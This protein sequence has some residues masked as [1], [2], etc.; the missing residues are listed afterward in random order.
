MEYD[1]TPEGNEVD[2]HMSP[3]R[4]FKS[5]LLVLNMLV[6]LV[7]M[8]LKVPGTDNKRS[9]PGVIYHRSSG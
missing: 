5:T 3:R 2:L 1:V 9:P 6:V 4:E 7:L 8:I